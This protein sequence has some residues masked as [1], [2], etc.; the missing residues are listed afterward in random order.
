MRAYYFRKLARYVQPKEFKR[1]KVVRDKTNPQISIPELLFLRWGIRTLRPQT[2]VE[3]GSFCGASTSIMADQLQRLGKG[4]LYAIDLFSLSSP[5]KGH[6]G[7]YWKTFDQTMKPYIGWFEK[8]EGDSR[9]IPWDR[10][11]DFLFIDGDHS[12]AGVSADIAKY[13]PF[14][15]QGGGIFLH[16]YL[17]SPET[18][19]LVKTA[20]DR[21]LLRDAT[22]RKLGVVSSLV[23]FQKMR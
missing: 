9:M 17:D 4:R 12:E 23:A 5:G 15:R 11:I 20:V 13:A 18:N 16:D 1:V 22:Y 7:D 14:V 10:P 6:G 19:S 8:I 21:T 2:V 3:I